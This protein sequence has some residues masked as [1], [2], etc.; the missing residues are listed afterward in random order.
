MAEAIAEARKGLAAGEVPVGAVVLSA[1]GRLVARA[2]NQPIGLLD[3]SAHAEI[4][5]LRRASQ[6]LGNY[7]LPGCTLY[8]TLEPCVMCAGALILARSACIVYGA[9][10]SRGGALESVYQIGSDGLLNHRLQ[11]ISGVM[12]EESRALLQDFFRCR[13]KGGFEL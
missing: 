9:A 1:E 6:Q 10:D 11:I 13:R 4:L 2:H 12:A 3:P 8:V 5:V 7:R